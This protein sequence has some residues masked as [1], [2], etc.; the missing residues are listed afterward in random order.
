MA[1]AEIKVYVEPTRAIDND[2][3]VNLLVMSTF[4]R[5]D[6]K[7]VRNRNQDGSPKMT[8]SILFSEPTVAKAGQSIEWR[9]KDRTCRDQDYEELKAKVVEVLGIS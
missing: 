9:Y 1:E 4:T 3:P 2:I 7:D 6:S 8:Y 5:K